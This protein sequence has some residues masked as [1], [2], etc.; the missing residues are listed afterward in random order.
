M[1][2]TSIDDYGR[3]ELILT[4]LCGNDRW[5]IEQ[6]MLGYSV[7]GDAIDKFADY[8]DAEEQGLLLKLPCKVGDILYII[9]KVSRGKY[10]IT[11]G[12]VKSFIY[13][14]YVIPRIEI[15]FENLNGFE[16]C[17]LNG[18]LNEGVFL[19][20][21]EAEQALAKMKEV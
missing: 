18:E 1:R 15:Y 13:Q 16:T 2:Y 11:N 6:G 10:E 17:F 20:K 14:A 12:I 9:Q 19:T 5:E 4:R 3:N 21:S 8:E 7:T